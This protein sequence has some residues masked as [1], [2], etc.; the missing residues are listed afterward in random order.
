MFLAPIDN[1]ASDS[2]V[3]FVT[4]QLNITSKKKMKKYTLL[5]ASLFS[6]FSLKAQITITQNDMPVIGDQIFQITD[7]S[8]TLDPGISGADLTWDFSSAS[9][10]F[11]TEYNIVDVPS[12]GMAAIFPGANL[13]ISE[14]NVSFSFFNSNSNSFEQHGDAMSGLG[15]DPI[16][17]TPAS[18]ILE[19]PLNYNDAFSTSYTSVMSFSAEEEGFYRI[20]IKHASTIDKEVDA[21]GTVITPEGTFDALRIRETET[22]SDSTF[23]QMTESSAP[24]WVGLDESI[25]SSYAWYS[26]NRKMPVARFDQDGTFHYTKLGASQAGIDEEAN[27]KQVIAYPNPVDAGY[28]INFRGLENISYT[29]YIYNANG[30]LIRTEKISGLNANMHT[31]NLQSGIYHYKIV[32]S[33][34]QFSG[35]VIIK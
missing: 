22:S 19:F 12:T 4:H 17:Y 11:S 10:A 14:D 31:E 32:A 6:L 9:E 24:M 16:V 26:P 7:T 23:L 29:M 21:W 18:T 15:F 20:I 35:S 8:Y 25:S 27:S 2:H 1:G 30:Q 28:G 33:S 5:T 13:A 3:H 34:Q